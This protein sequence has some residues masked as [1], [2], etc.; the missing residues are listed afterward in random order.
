LLTNIA[1]NV[2][3]IDSYNVLKPRTVYHL[4]IP[5]II[6]EQTT[7]AYIVAEHDIDMAFAIKIM[8]MTGR[9]E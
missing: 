8:Q 6:L 9:I 2:D 1:A 3:N 4:F 7:T 5:L